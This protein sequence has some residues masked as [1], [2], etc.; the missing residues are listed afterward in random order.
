MCEWGGGSKSNSAKLRILNLS[1]HSHL[2][3]LA[4]EVKLEMLSGEPRLMK[5]QGQSP[6][7]LEQHALLPISR[8]NAASDKQAGRG[9]RQAWFPRSPRPAPWVNRKDLVTGPLCILPGWSPPSLNSII[10]PDPA[11]TP[12]RTPSCI[13][14][15]PDRARGRPHR[16]KSAMQTVWSTVN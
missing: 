6:L 13:P 8:L 15:S 9:Q 10:L 12:S 3:Y 2:W 11:S 4:L 1:L 7:D 14:P 5:T 16:D